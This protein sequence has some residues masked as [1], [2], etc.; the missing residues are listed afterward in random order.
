M[1]NAI[2]LFLFSNGKNCNQINFLTDF[3]SIFNIFNMQQ[4]LRQL[5]DL[6]LNN[7]TPIY[8]IDWCLFTAL[9]MEQYIGN[10]QFICSTDNFYGQHPNIFVPKTFIYNH[11]HTSEQILNALLQ[12]AEVREHIKS[13]GPGKL[14]TWLLDEES[15]RLAAELDLEICLPSVQLRLHWDNKINTNRLAEKAGVPCVPYIISAIENYEQLCSITAHLGENLVV[16]MPH[17]MAGETTF[18]IANEKD[19][20]SCKDEI[21]NGEEMKIMRRINCR[22]AGLEACITKHG[23]VASP[24]LVELFGLPET[25][26]YKGGWSG[27]EFFPNA[28]PNHII[29]SAM[30]YAVKM[31]E[32]LRSVGYKGY[33]EPDFLIDEDT[34]N[35]YLGEMNLRFSGFTPLVNNT[36][37][38]V[39][40]IPLFLL[41][42]AEWLDVEYEL[43]VYALNNYWIEQ[44]NLRTLS[45]LHVKNVEDALAVPIPT[46]IYRMDDSEN[47]IFERFGLSPQYIQSDNEIFWFSTS[48]KDST[49]GRGEELGAFFL[50]ARVTN[51]GKNL[52]SKAKA[53]I[54][55]LLA[56]PR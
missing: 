43:D 52:N 24:L 29:Q 1:D 40:E 12:N 55:G 23:T 26:I 42:L 27:D 56:V 4:Q 33:F 39:N 3:I 48:A 35:L 2:L 10:I 11:Q 18:F 14:L 22:A 41:H 9:G 7:T 34:D 31:G 47:V 13:R 28:F 50:P 5:R 36:N 44:Q 37:Q 19:F 20:D 6:M 49:I 30:E 38:A 51:D 15:E 45:F 32:A 53:W 46:G 8:F 25:N 17:G 54:K 21:C 16:Q